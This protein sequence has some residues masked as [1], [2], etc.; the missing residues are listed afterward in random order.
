MIIPETY[1]LRKEQDLPEIG[2]RGCIL[3]HRKTNAHLF[4]IDTDDDNKVFSIAFKTTP[5]DDT[6]VPHILEHSVLCGSDRYPVKDPFVE[7]MKGSLNTFLNAFTYPDKTVYPVASCNDQDFKNLMGV[8]MDAVFHPAI[9][10]NEK[11]FRQEGWH[12]ELSDPERELKINGVV[13]N[14]MRG[15]YSDPDE[16][17]YDRTAQSLFP[18]L[19]YAKDSGGDPKHI[20]ELSYEDF[21]AFHKRFYHPSNS[22]IFLYGNMDFTERL[23]WLDEAYLCHYDAIDPKT[24][25]PEE[26]AFEKPVEVRACYGISEGDP[27]DH[28][29][30]YGKVVGGLFDP[31][32][33]LAFEV[34]SYA[35][36][37]APGAPI[38]QALLDAGIGIDVYGGYDSGFRQPIF[39]IIAKGEQ[40]DQAEAFRQII[41]DVLKEQ[42]EK[43]ISKKTLLAGINNIEFSLRE[44]DYGRMPKGLVYGVSSYGTWLHDDLSPM[45]SLAFNEPFR[46]LKEKLKGDYFERLTEEAL[47]NNPHGTIVSVCPKEGLN[48][49]EDRLLSEKLAAY[50]A[51]L[52]K[53]EIGIIV[54]ETKALK[55]YQDTPD[56]PEA[57]MSV[58]LLSIDDIRKEAPKAVNEFREHRGTP[59]VWH[60][61]VTSGIAYADIRFPLSHLASE[62]LPYLSV[63][64]NLYTQM[65]TARFGYGE[66]NDELGLKTGGL[67]YEVS[68]FTKYHDSEDVTEQFAIR[69]KFLYEYAE[70]AFDLI[71]EITN[72]TDFSDEK[73]LRE[74]LTEIH[75][76]MQQNMVSG[77]NATGLKRVLSYVSQQAK[78]DDDLTGIGFYRFLD[79]IVTHFDE[80]KEGLIRKMEA[81]KRQIFARRGVLVSLTAENSAYE[82]VA[83]AICRFLHKLPEGGETMPKEKNRHYRLEKKNEGFQTASQVQYNCIGGNYKKAGFA[84]SGSLLVFR[85]IMNSEYLWQNLRVKGG[86]YGCSAMI[87]SNGELGFASYRDPNLKESYE[88]YR[89]IPEYLRTL[90]IDARDMTKYMIG[91]VSS[92]DAPLNPSAKGARAFSMYLTGR[93]DEDVQK[94]RDEVLSTDTEKLRALAPLVQAVIDEETCCTVG[95]AQKVEEQKELFRSIENLS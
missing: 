15:A 44:A 1:E 34:L 14:E 10:H 55:D 49:E 38:R 13:Y 57:L 65:S 19:T 40:P 81:L 42:I 29:Y 80:R 11:I 95:N 47:L 9:Y 39:N 72:R 88:I 87:G 63:L 78:E 25:I 22:Y 74:S 56:T 61:L 73:R 92:M 79:D 82:A 77:G 50:K 58:P 24:E 17:V 4:L 48:E 8:Y 23:T 91:T 59:I 84:Y 60:D 75:S 54:E 2:G 46:A 33:T 12:Y 7:L 36:L 6:G 3:R 37:N 83:D 89:Q 68:T 20:P 52:S 70:D 53:E 66:L 94:E 21:L 43:G 16:I 32:K 30:A 93:T 26:P 28:F 27:E 51:S 67:T 5:E 86:A 90:K 76:Q 64:K 41:E 62:D 18:H 85:T 31:V 35:L 71:D 45:L 69:V